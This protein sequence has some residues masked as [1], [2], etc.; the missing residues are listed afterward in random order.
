M[1]L[2]DL[3]YAL[4][5]LTRARGFTITVVATL[6]LGIGA[7][8]AVLSALDRIL[9][10]PLP[11][12]DADRLIYISHGDETSSVPIDIPPIRLWDWR[13]RSSSFEALAG[14][15]TEDVTETAGDRHARL[16][17]PVAHRSCLGTRFHG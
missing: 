14:Y 1:T 5:S 7:N 15:Y 11:F 9:L 13:D 2:S 8:S 3:K 17:R 12:P 6:A 16:S 4:R 10:R